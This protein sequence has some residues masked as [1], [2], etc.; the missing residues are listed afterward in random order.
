MFSYFG[1]RKVKFHCNLKGEDQF[2]ENSSDKISNTEEISDNIE[3]FEKVE[4]TISQ[5][6]SEKE[7][8]QE[9]LADPCFDE[10]LGIYEV[11]NPNDKN[12]GRVQDLEEELSFILKR[13]YIPDNLIYFWIDIIP[14][15]NTFQLL[16]SFSPFASVELFIAIPDFTCPGILAY[17][18]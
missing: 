10:L 18:L 15:K 4:Q 1:M 14:V 13:D 6:T 9:K 3:A 7:G 2:T 11:M 12:H 17:Y 16:L 8:G 5:P